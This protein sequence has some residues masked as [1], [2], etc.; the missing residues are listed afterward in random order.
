[1]K[2]LVRITTVPV[3]LDKLLGNQLDFMNRHYDV[4]TVSSDRAALSKVA[5]KYGINHHH[6]EMTR[7]ITPLKDLKSLWKV[8]R[9]LKKHKPEIVHTHTPKAGLIGMSAAFFAGVPIRMHTVAG[10]PLMEASGIKRQVLK[11]AE[12]TTYSFANGVYPN[13]FNMAKIISSYGFCK[14]TKMKVLGNGSSNGIDLDHFSPSFI[15]SIQK[16]ALRASLGISEDDFVFVFVGRLVK[17]KGINELVKAF[18]SLSQ[19]HP[20]MSVKLLLVGDYEEKLDPLHP[21]TI[22]EINHHPHIIN[23]G[24]QDDVRPYFAISNALAFPS[25][26]EGFPNV[27]LQAAAMELPCIVTDINGCNEII[28]DHHNG[29]FVPL[30]NSQKLEDAMLRL[31]ENRELYHSLKINTRQSIEERFIQNYLWLEMQKEYNHQLS[32]RQ[33]KEKYKEKTYRTRV[34]EKAFSFFSL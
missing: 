27:V 2:K 22:K 18:T 21:E 4:T 25:Y 24:F 3:S 12:R 9:F 15:T 29:L 34:L 10:L 17:D 28:T 23:V 6:I 31:Y 7:Q 13:S 26:R 14:D 20:K 1:M 19:H 33:K 16:S 8:Y 5:E 11:M 30:K 32:N